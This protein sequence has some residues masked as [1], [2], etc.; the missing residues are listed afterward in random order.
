MS[1]AMHVMY[2]YHKTPTICIV[3]K[4][5]WIVIDL[6]LELE[7]SLFCCVNVLYVTSFGGSS[8]GEAAKIGII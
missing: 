7:L 4:T 5:I 3:V 1:C 2:F 8:S 6:Y